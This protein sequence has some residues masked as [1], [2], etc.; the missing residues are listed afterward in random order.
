MRT[1][2]WLKCDLEVLH[3][4]AQIVYAKKSSQGSCASP[5][6]S[7]TSVKSPGRAKLTLISM[8]TEP[9][10][11]KGPGCHA[12][13]AKTHTVSSLL[14]LLL[15]LLLLHHRAVSSHGC[16]SP[17]EVNITHWGNIWEAIWGELRRE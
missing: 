11:E 6:L 12:P 2:R 17:L 1:D 8:E 10:T 16:P 14:P 5:P 13:A 9:G 4:A 7:S 3:E 15:L